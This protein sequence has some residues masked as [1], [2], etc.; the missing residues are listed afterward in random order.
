[1]SK[2]GQSWLESY[3][4]Y[5]FGLGYSLN[6]EAYSNFGQLGFI[7]IF[8]LS[9]IVARWLSEPNFNSKKNKF[10][11]YCGLSLLYIWFTMPRRSCYYVLNFIVYYVLIMGFALLLT[12]KKEIKDEI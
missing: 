5:T 4:D 6:A 8:I 7:W 2:E 9:I 10:S 1:M 12:C 11:Q 3:Y